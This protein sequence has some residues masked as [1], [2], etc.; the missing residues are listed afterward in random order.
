VFAH[1]T[2]DLRREILEIV[3]ETHPVLA[4]AWKQ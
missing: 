1:L 3:T 4:E 2:P